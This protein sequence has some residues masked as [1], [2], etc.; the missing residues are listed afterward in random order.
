[1]RGLLLALLVLSAV[2]VGC[3]PR[4]TMPE[5]LTLTELTPR[6]VRPNDRVDILGR[7]LPVGQVGDATIVFRGDLYRPGES[8]LIDRTIEITTAKLERDRLSFD[9]SDALVERF[10]GT[11][12]GAKHT[13]FRGTVEVQLPG[14]SSAMPVTGSIKGD[15]VFDVVPRSPSKRVEDATRTKAEAAEA[16]FGWK[17]EPAAGATGGLVV[18]ALRPEGPA[19]R[20]GVREGDLIVGFAGVTALEA[21]DVVP[22]GL[23]GSLPVAVAR[24]GE[25]LDLTIDARGFRGDVESGLT[26]GAV[27]L[28]TILVLMLLFGSRLGRALSWFS[29]RMR[30]ELARHRPQGGS[31]ALAVIRAAVSDVRSAN[32]ATKSAVGSFA[33][34]LVA[35]GVTLSFATLP[36]VELS[37]RAELDLGILYLLSVTALLAMG[38]VTGGFGSTGSIV[39]S[40]AR[41]V[42]EVVVCEL[43]AAS[44]LGAVVVTAG[45]LRVRDVVLG[46][47]GPGGAALETGAWPWAWNALR[48]P[49]L[50]LLFALFFVTAL[51]DGAKPAQGRGRS[52]IGSFAFFFAEWTH[53][54]VMCGLGTIAFLGG[55]A[56]PGVAPSELDASAWLKV[57]GGAVFLVKCWGLAFVVLLV[58]AALP[59]IRPHVL[60]RLGL[61]VLL[62]ACVIGLGITALTLRF[63]LLPAAERILGLVTMS[64]VVGTLLLL[65]VHLFGALRSARPDDARMRVRVNPLL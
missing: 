25:Q 20:A 65:G 32:V 52:S 64:T 48:S 24:A 14:V 31:V 2:V 9:V 1:M 51:V 22:S 33:P 12:E 36:F 30:E 37:R 56:L 60:L 40:R 63:P 6:A 53:V 4:R 19:A 61:R 42:L 16:F 47:V 10:T 5:L 7:D 46:Q 39:G 13:T 35:A 59:R 44:A 41:A 45:S 38:L 11:G 8:P 49:Q 21:S 58:R 29:H 55:Y 62:P 54:F 28:L 43:P 26:S 34:V 18:R 27:V 15:I 57:A 23:E 3:S 50:F 17:L